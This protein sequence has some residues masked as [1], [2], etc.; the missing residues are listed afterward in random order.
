MFP[1]F[2]IYDIIKKSILK[3]SES[4][5]FMIGVEIICRNLY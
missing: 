1:F 3:E 4:R 2:N 5:N